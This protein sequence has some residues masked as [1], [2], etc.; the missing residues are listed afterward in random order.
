MNRFALMLSLGVV[1][2]AGAACEEEASGPCGAG[3][4]G[5]ILEV[6]DG[7]TVRINELDEKIRLLGIDT[8][9]TN[10]TNKG[11]CPLPWGEMTPEEQATYGK[12]CCFGDQAKLQVVTL[13]PPGTEVCLVNPEGGDLAKDSFGRYLADL[14]VNDSWFNGKL[15]VAGLARAN[16]DFPHPTRSQELEDA[17][18]KAN[19]N[20]AGLWGFCF[21]P[22]TGGGGEGPCE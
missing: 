10:A 7:D 14:Y 6:T 2:L 5:T 16:K 18:T 12:S 9:E 13:L 4:L 19:L 1:L 17:Q 8:P 20:L 22:G 21:Q 15:V 3:I 11:D